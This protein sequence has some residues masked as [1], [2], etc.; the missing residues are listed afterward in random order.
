MKIRTIPLNAYLLK[1]ASR[2]QSCYTEDTLEKVTWYRWENKKPVKLA[3][4][5]SLDTSGAPLVAVSNEPSNSPLWQQFIRENLELDAFGNTRQSLGTAIF[6]PLQQKDKPTRWICYTFGSASSKIR[7]RSMEPRFGLIVALNEIC[8]SSTDAGVRKAQHRSVSSGP[9]VADFRSGSDT[10]IEDFGFDSVLD[11]LKAAGGNITD[12]TDNQK[13]RSIFGARSFKSS[14]SVESIDCLKKYATAAFKT[15]RSQ[16][17]TDQYGFVDQIV[18]VDDEATEEKLRLEVLDQ[19]ENLD[20]RVDVL[21]PADLEKTDNQDAICYYARPKKSVSKASD[22]TLTLGAVKNIL[23]PGKVDLSSELRFL[24]SERKELFK[25]PILDCLTTEIKLDDKDYVLFDGDFYKVDGNFLQRV[26]K[27]ISQIKTVDL[28]LKYDGG[29]EDK[30]I[31]KVVNQNKAR[32]LN[33][34]QNFARPKGESKF[35]PCDIIDVD[36]RAL[37]HAKRKGRSSSLTYLYTQATRS[38]ELL[39]EDSDLRSQ[40]KTHIDKNP[41]DENI[42]IQAKSLIDAL[43]NRSHGCEMILALLGDWNKKDLTNLPLLAK[44][45]LLPTLQAIR[46]TGFEPKISLITQ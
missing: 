27:Q 30:W 6:Y 14:E 11:L 40:F 46:R 24:D 18:P 13:T 43:G 23:N 32:F 25:V 37:I 15:Y 8:L 35:E 42:R 4:A 39:T 20:S 38:C 41:A 31:E 16:K 22:K 17:Y 29:R 12:E 1:P 28:D 44:L 3:D 26:N 45:S 34:D 36:R 21:L 7:R 10:D 5:N 33:L 9:Y 2:P 19:I